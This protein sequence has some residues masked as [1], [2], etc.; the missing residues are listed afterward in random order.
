MADGIPKQNK[1]ECNLLPILKQLRAVLCENGSCKQT[2][3][4]IMH[5]LYLLWQ[6]QV[7]FL[8]MEM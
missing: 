8:T 6:S 5:F 1:T 3:Y 4:Y 2:L 7:W